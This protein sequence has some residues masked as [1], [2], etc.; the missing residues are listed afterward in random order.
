MIEKQGRK[1]IEAIEEHGKQLVKY[2]SEKELKGE[3][4]P[5]NFISF[6]G[7]LAFYRNIKDGYKTL[8]K[9][10]DN[11]KKIKSDINEVVKGRNISEEQTRAIK[12]IKKYLK[13]DKNKDK[14]ILRK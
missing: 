7:P 2:S 3:N 10:E 14:K 11:R 6:K 5:Q 1:Q 13:E 12:N 9:A 8:E 4:G